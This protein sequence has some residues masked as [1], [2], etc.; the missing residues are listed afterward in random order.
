[1]LS[2]DLAC[3]AEVRVCASTV[4]ACFD[5]EPLP[6]A[7]TLRPA[8][9]SAQ[10][11]QWR[12]SRA[13]GRCSPWKP[14]AAHRQEERAALVRGRTGPHVS[15]ALAELPSRSHANPNLPETAHI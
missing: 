7:G 4:D 11:P 2:R 10:G 15:D 9:G 1:M 8:I 14:R 5:I 6:L 3:T 12:A 13:L